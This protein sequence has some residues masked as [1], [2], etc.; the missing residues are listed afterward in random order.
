MLSYVHF[1]NGKGRQNVCNRGNFRRDHHNNYDACLPHA[2]ISRTRK[3]NSIFLVPFF[4]GKR[5]KKWHGKKAGKRPKFFEL[6]RKRWRKTTVF[7]SMWK[8][9]MISRLNCP[10]SGR[11]TRFPILLSAIWQNF[12]A[13]EKLAVSFHFPRE[14]EMGEIFNAHLLISPFLFWE[15]AAPLFP[16]KTKRKK[17]P[18]LVPGFFR[19]SNRCVKEEEDQLEPF[20]Q[21]RRFTMPLPS[22]VRNLSFLRERTH[23]WAS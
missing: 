20:F 11:K 16:V 19:E 22:T 5:Q 3:Y 2:R 21:H 6:V 18:L 7:L 12:K 13:W 15:E 9:G 4:S 1:P 8:I 14:S 17:A 10:N 23:T